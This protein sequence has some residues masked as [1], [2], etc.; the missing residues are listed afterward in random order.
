MPL[1]A[2][3]MSPSSTWKPRS[4]FILSPN[5]VCSFLCRSY[6]I[7]FSDC[8]RFLF[9][10][11]RQAPRWQAHVSSHPVSTQT[12]RL[13]LNKELFNERE[14]TSHSFMTKPVKKQVI[15]GTSSVL[16][17]QLQKSLVSIRLESE[18]LNV[19]LLLLGRAWGILPSV[20]LA[21]TPLESLGRVCGW[22]NYITLFADDM[23]CM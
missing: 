5:P 14:N 17:K 21:V 4:I 1:K 2:F 13:W 22:E 6:S 9:H 16:Q 20:S 12:M 3:L 11:E 19:F 15:G 23:I 7:L 8:P 10:S 18:K